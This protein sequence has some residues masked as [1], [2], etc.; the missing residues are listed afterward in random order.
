LRL[1][2]TEARQLLEKLLIDKLPAE[3]GVVTELLEV[4][5]YL[6][7]AITQAAAYL[8]E[9]KTLV[10]E[11]MRLLRNTERD[12][13]E[14]LEAEF[15]DDTRYRGAQNAVANT[16]VVS[17][18][19]IRKNAEAAI[20]LS[21][22]GQVESKA[23]P[24]S[25][26]PPVGSEQKMT[27]AIG[28]LCGYSFL[29]VRADG[30]TYDM[31]RLVHVASRVW[32]TRQ[33]A[34]GEGKRAALVHLG[35]IFS[36]DSWEERDR[37]RDFLPHVMKAVEV[38][39]EDEDWGEEACHVGYWVGRCLQ[40][41]GRHREAVAMLERVVRAREETL[42]KTHPSRLASQHELASAYRAD[43][44]VKKA[45]RLLEQVVK[46]REETLDKTH[47]D[48]L[49]SQHNLA[50][51]YRADGR[52]KEAIALLEQV[53]K[54]G[55][56][57]LDKTHPDRLASQHNL[58]WAYRADG[59]VKE[60]ITL[61]EQVVK[62]REETL[63]KAHPHRMVS[64][65]LLASAYLADGRIKEAITSLEQVVKTH[66]ETL[67]KTHPSRLASQHELAMAY[68]ADGRVKE[69]SDLF[70]HLVAVRRGTLPVDHP[71]LTKSERWLDFLQSESHSGG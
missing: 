27:R 49:A 14:L 2:E 8:N 51:A 46:T 48:R 12:M 54:T 19:Q 35:K 24:R 41:E 15:E 61:L 4:L 43:G 9:N 30:R 3:D 21:F 65:C 7:L 69:A 57:T 71:D 45:I 56:E 40:V 47:P 58:A 60:A 20:L 22:I 63:D 31:H 1:S 6:P 10:V 64:Q 62:T 33:D 5:T 44:R 17:F 11:Y 42:D 66:E 25:M 37:W 53:V 18:E 59:R 23:I 50:M 52:I 67:D 16:W 29:S 38:Y 36:T 70:Q 39:G 28:V 34:A 26:L 13:V 68:L 32:L 55:E